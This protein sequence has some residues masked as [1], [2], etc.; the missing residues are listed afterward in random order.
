MPFPNGLARQR[1]EHLIYHCQTLSFLLFWS[2]KLIL[3][4]NTLMFHFANPVGGNK[5]RTS[6]LQST[7]SKLTYHVNSW[8]TALERSV[9]GFEPTI[10]G[11]SI[12][13]STHCHYYTS[14]IMRRPA[15]DGVIKEGMCPALSTALKTK[16][17]K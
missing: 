14:Y 3:R 9:V 12:L 2:I 11:P 6:A 16:S 10:S 15:P 8:I 17:L 7:L 1:I 13:C 4:L 5:K